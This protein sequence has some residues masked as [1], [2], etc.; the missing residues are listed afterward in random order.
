MSQDCEALGDVP[1]HIWLGCEG[2][3]ERCPH[4]AHVPPHRARPAAG[5]PG[6]A[7]AAAPAHRVCLQHK[8]EQSANAAQPPMLIPIVGSAISAA[9]I[10]SGAPDI[11]G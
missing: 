3:R 1:T 2:A 5:P 9:C 7:L 11:C 8:P 6:A 4:A 10:R